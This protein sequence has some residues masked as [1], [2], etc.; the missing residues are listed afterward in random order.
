MQFNIVILDHTYG[1]DTDSGSHLNA[2]RF[3][4]TIERMKK[5]NLLAENTRIFATHISHE[6]NPTHD[7][8]SKY[9][10]EHGYEIAYD[11]LV[12]QSGI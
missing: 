8:L 9:A 1:Q 3:I 12:I 6:G 11:G 4:E 2:N 10:K 7:E 5:E